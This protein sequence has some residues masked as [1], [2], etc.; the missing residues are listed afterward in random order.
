MMRRTADAKFVVELKGRCSRCSTERAELD[1][2]SIQAPLP[3]SRRTD[4][5]RFCLFPVCFASLVFLRPA[6][7]PQLIWH[8]APD[9]N[10]PGT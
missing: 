10:L 5:P 9:I 2:I 1:I 8:I 4:Q 7:N 3:S 6:S